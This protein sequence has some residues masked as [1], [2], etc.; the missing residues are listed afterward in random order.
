MAEDFPG[1]GLGIT[2]DLGTDFGNL[3]GAMGLQSD[4]YSYTGKY[5]TLTESVRQR[6]RQQEV[7]ALR[8][9]MLQLEAQRLT[10]SMMALQIRMMLVITMKTT[11]KSTSTIKSPTK[12]ATGNAWA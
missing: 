4:P 10:Q 12:F 8:E 11:P 9:H 2:G 7:L 6:Q 1:S 5:G 3:T